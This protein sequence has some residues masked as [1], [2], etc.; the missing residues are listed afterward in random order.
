MSAE[1]VREVLG[2]A[3]P[4]SGRQWAAYFRVSLRTIRTWMSRGMLLDLWA[5]PTTEQWQALQAEAIRSFWKR[6]T[7]LE[8]CK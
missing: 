6:I 8:G 1:E 4:Y 3:R 5:G 2:H 7:F